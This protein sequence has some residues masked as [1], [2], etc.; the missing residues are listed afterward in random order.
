LKT[1]RQPLAGKCVD[2]RKEGNSKQN[3]A[4]TGYLQKSFS[5]SK[6]FCVK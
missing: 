3:S 2:L 6:A 5:N 1:G 4:S